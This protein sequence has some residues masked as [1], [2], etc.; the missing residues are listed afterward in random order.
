MV[1]SAIRV[2]KIIELVSLSEN[3]LTNAEISRALSIPTGSLSFLLSDLVEYE[4]LLLDSSRKR[5]TL[6]PQ[7]LI[8]AGRYIDRLDVVELG[9]PII[10]ELTLSIGESTGIAIKVHWEMVIVCKYDARELLIQ[11]MQVGETLPMHSTACGKV[12]LAYLSEDKIEHYLSKAELKP[13]TDNT[14]TDVHKL[15]RELTQ[16]RSNGLAWSREENIE[17]LFA[18]AAPVFDYNR[19]VVAAMMVAIPSVRFS[20][21]KEALA[22]KYIRE[23]SSRLSYQLGCTGTPT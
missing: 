19:Y 22:E 15:R 17:N 4:Y 8:T 23:E 16:I 3:G 10:R 1:K 13:L 9:K 6:G 20:K 18:V 12:F 2:F 21:E 5:Y 7:I 11:P 14:I